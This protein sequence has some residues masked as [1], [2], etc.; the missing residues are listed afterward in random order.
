MYWARRSTL[1]SSSAASISSRMQKGVGLTFRM[2]KN[3]ATPMKACSPPESCMRFLMIFPGGAALI[4]MPDSSTFSGSDRVISAE[5]PP[6]S[7]EK[8]TAKFSL[9]LLKASTKAVFISP[10]RRPMML[11]FP[12]CWRWLLEV[13]SILSHS[14]SFDDFLFLHATCE[15]S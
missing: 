9:I 8:V 1:T 6:K 4:S 12:I 5:P 2:A 10:S 14:L 7:S 13:Y 15:T 3:R 11:L